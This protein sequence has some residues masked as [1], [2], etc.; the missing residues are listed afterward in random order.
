MKNK[1][2]Y[3]HELLTPPQ[4]AD[5]KGCSRQYIYKLIR[6]GALDVEEVGGR[7]LIVENK[8][9]KELE[10][11]E[12]NLRKRVESLEAT[13]KSWESLVSGLSL[14]MTK[15]QETVDTLKAENN[16]LKRECQKIP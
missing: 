10:C 1:D 14:D 6:S 4:A 2:N 8:K 11:G 15:L 16:Q 12:T 5:L 3:T 7:K 13:L 9:F